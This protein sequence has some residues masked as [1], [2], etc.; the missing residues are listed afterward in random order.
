VVYV[1]VVHRNRG[2]HAVPRVGPIAFRLPAILVTQTTILFVACLSPREGPSAPVLDGGFDQPPTGGGGSGGSSAPTAGSGGR[3]ET[4]TGDAAGVAGAGGAAGMAGAGGAA[5]GGGRTADAAAATPNASLDSLTVSAGVLRPAFDASLFE[6]SVE[7]P[8][9]EPVQVFAVAELDSSVVRVDGQIV[10][11]SSPAT[12]R[13]PLGTTVVNVVVTAQD[14]RTTATY[15]ITFTRIDRDPPPPPVVSGESPAFTRMPTWTFRS[16]GGDGDGTFRCQLDRD[17]FSNGGEVTTNGRFTP[18]SSLPDGSHTLYVQERDQAGNWSA[19]GRAEILIT[20]G[21]LVHYRMDNNAQ[22]SGLN[23]NHG[24]LQG[25]R[26]TTDRSGRANGALQF[27][28]VDDVMRLGPARNAVDKR[29]T[30][31]VWLKI[32]EQNDLKYFFYGEFFAMGTSYGTEV[33]MAVS[34]PETEAASG[35]ATLNTWTHLAGT[36][37]GTDI[38]LYVNGTLRSTTRHPASPT[39]QQSW[40]GTSTIGLSNDVLNIYWAGALDDLRVYNRVLSAAEIQDLFNSN[41]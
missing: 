40:P 20:V 35:I 15:R 26:P 14:G 11:R 37:D 21:P 39:R 13:L 3:N 34:T 30:V 18:T 41:D 9:V 36:Y 7:V 5:G 2:V 23:Q 17:D 22:D 16:G 27:D 31:A 1:F 32:G 25:P 29:C 10:D 28:G 33:F 4:A 19:S 24:T 6:Y 8:S 12:I 38:R